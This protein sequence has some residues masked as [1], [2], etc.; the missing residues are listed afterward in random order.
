MRPQ[1]EQGALKGGRACFK[2][3]SKVWLG[4]EYTNLNV[5]L[6]ALK[7]NTVTVSIVAAEKHCIST[8]FHAH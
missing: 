4:D 2:R 5:R 8:D 1:R 6:G 3:N 7:T